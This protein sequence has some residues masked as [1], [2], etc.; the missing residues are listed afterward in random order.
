MTTGLATTIEHLT[1]T[2]NEA[3]DAVL[4]RA[5]DSLVPP[6]QQGAFRAVLAR[7]CLE[8]QKRIVS[9]WHSLD[10]ERRRTLR[11]HNGSIAVA[12]RDAVLAKEVHLC[13]NG[14]ELVLEFREYELLPALLTACEDEGNPN[15]GLAAHTLLQL[16]ELLYDELAIPRETA[17]RRDPQ[18]VRQH[19]VASLELSVMRFHRHR[20][21][22][23]LEAFLLLV[24]RD[25]VTLKRI[26]SD[27]RHVI[28]LPLTEMLTHSPRPGVM[29]LVLS[30]LDDAHAPSSAIRL[31]AYRHDE[32]FV[33]ALLKKIGHEPTPTVTQN[34]RRIDNIVWMLSE[35]VV[36]GRLDEAAQR[37]AI[38]LAMRSGVNRQAVFKMIEM[39]LLR[40]KS[41]G[42]ITAALA[43]GDFNGA[44]ANSLAMKALRDPEPQVQANVLP[45]LR[46]RGIP[47][48]VARLLELLDSP[49]PTV[50][51]AARDSLSEFTFPRF[52]AVYD[53]LDDEVRK[54][55]G[56]MVVR[57]D[58][59][60]P[61]GLMQ[62]LKAPA[63]SRRLRGI[64]MAQIMNLASRIE[65]ALHERM[66][67][68]DHLVRAEAARAL[69]RCDTPA[70]HDVLRQA[71][72]DRS[73]AVREAAESSLQALGQTAVALPIMPPLPPWQERTTT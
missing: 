41:G 69:G 13:R 2:R 58:P 61:A 18:M 14:C 33:E 52:L 35:E 49:H 60:A 44:E 25:N 20:V 46:H 54:S 4:V 7:S 21:G 72:T 24:H 32:K 67:D 9:Q 12:L 66:H 38:Q 17:R 42:R 68:E 63:R 31:L 34:L 56:A 5:L 62:E 22:A 6:V 30:F 73:G 57:V 19:L 37:S 26:L 71:L 50:R 11:E 45:Q 29:R 48:A 65:Q 28:Y 16:A 70:T 23:V 40:G 27:P 64:A 59:D 1:T 51:A 47:G 10:D 15:R 39:V 43:L 55:T 53:L 8:G 3:A 36:I